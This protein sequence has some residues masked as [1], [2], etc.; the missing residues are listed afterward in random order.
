MSKVCIKTSPNA[1]SAVS[2]MC[3]IQMTKYGFNNKQ[4]NKLMIRSILHNISHPS[5]LLSLRVLLSLNLL[6]FFFSTNQDP[7]Y[8]R[9]SILGCTWKHFT[10]AHIN[11]IFPM[12]M[13]FI[14]M[15][16]PFRTCEAMSNSYVGTSA[17]DSVLFDFFLMIKVGK[18]C[19]LGHMCKYCKEQK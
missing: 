14:F 4:K 3:G 18:K 19:Y 10:F 9:F 13:R 8:L 6:V 17:V 11:D 2:C 16:L 5:N 1:S 7:E 12:A 15:R